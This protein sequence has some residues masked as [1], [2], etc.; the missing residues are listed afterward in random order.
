MNESTV[1][2]TLFALLLASAA[3]LLIG[4][5]FGVM[6]K[7]FSNRNTRQKLEAQLNSSQTELIELKKTPTEKPDIEKLQKQKAVQ[8]KLIKNFMKTNLLLKKANQVGNQRLDETQRKLA[9]QKVASEQWKTK[10]QTAAESYE[11]LKLKIK[12]TRQNKPEVTQAA[13]NTASIESSEV[14]TIQVANHTG[15]IR[16]PTIGTPGITGSAA[17]QTHTTSAT[18]AEPVKSLDKAQPAKDISPVKN[19]ETQASADDLTKIKGIGPTIAKALQEQGITHFSQ[20]ARMDINEVRALDKKMGRY[21][22]MERLNW[23]ESARNLCESN[24][25][26]SV[27]A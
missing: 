11:Q 16:V 5:A 9:L 1:A 6:F 13:K 17:I 24:E 8:D 25:N 2:Y 21:G 7:S 22:R 14:V 4:S 26:Q 10:S 19:N 20:M 27:A 12:A 18:F 23:V 3:C 15:A